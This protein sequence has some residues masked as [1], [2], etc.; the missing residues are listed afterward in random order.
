MTHKK[1]PRTPPSINLASFADEHLFYEAQMFVNAREAMPK[2]LPRTFE[3][4]ALIEVCVLH[5]R[6]L[7]DCFYLSTPK[8]DDVIAADYVAAWDRQ[9][10]PVSTLLENGRTRA[11]KEMAHLTTRRIPGG[12]PGK[13]WDFD[14]LSAELRPAIRDFVGLVGVGKLPQR[15]VSELQKI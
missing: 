1:R 9:R 7:V 2:V 5:F 13:V 4:N 11:N 8:A 12:P 14:A 3:M 10:P 15:V 6:N